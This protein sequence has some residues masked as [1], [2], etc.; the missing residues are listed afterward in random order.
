MTTVAPPTGARFVSSHATA[1]DDA[2]RFATGPRTRV[3]LTGPGSEP[4][5]RAALTRVWRLAGQPITVVVPPHRDPVGDV[6]AAWVAEHAVAG[7][8]VEH[9]TSD[10][11]SV[12]CVVVSA[13]GPVP[14]CGC[15]APPCASCLDDPAPCAGCASPLCPDCAGGGR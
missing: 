8:R 6:A 14:W 1:V 9:R 10:A 5:V 2:A 15:V 11:S 4:A 13:S 3:R 7:V 12:P